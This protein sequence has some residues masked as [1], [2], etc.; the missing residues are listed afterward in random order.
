VLV[1][2]GT[3]LGEAGRLRISTGTPEEQAR[4]LA[5]LDG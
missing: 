2:A 1:R 5:A 3:A 4:L